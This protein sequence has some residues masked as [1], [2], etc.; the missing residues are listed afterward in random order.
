MAADIIWSDVVGAGTLADGGHIGDLLKIARAHVDDAVRQNRLTQKDARQVY[1]AMIPAAIQNA[2]KFVMD[3]QLLES[4]I[5]KS[6][7]D[8]KAAKASADNEYAKMLAEIDK[9]Y[10][11]SYALDANDELVRSSLVDTAD[12]KLDYDRDLVKEKKESEEKNNMVDGV[13]DTQIAKVVADI[14]LT[15]TQEELAAQKVVG[16]KQ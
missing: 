4:Q 16:R 12:G 1:T 5:D 11:F 15:N 2:M 9:V 6:V 14:I 13:I 3:E 10:G 8:A 7:A